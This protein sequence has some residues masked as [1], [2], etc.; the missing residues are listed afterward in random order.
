MSTP[1]DLNLHARLSA[2]AVATLN[3]LC[4]E[5]ARPSSNEPKRPSAEVLL[6]AAT[7]N[8]RRYR[9]GR[10]QLGTKIISHTV[11]R[12]IKRAACPMDLIARLQTPNYP[13]AAEVQLQ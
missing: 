4:E 5:N 10:S 11:L 1:K 9:G 3:H 6:G 2:E 7:I 8:A 13:E 12:I